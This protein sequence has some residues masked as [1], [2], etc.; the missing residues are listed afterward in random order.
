MSD[1]NPLSDVSL[2]S[3]FFYSVGC[4]VILWVASVAAQKLFRLM[5]LDLF[6]FALG[7]FAVDGKRKQ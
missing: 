5:L 2:G 6:L 1:I 4:G 3:G 7:A